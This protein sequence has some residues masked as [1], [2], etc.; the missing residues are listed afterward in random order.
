MILSA[1]SCQGMLI[2]CLA[3]FGTESGVR[4]QRYDCGCERVGIVGDEDVDSMGQAHPLC[5][6]ACGHDRAAREKTSRTLILTPPPL[7]K[8]AT[9][10]IV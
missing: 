10:T 3:Q 9:T 6:N 2:A 1:P 5:A 4:Q 8:G 7:S